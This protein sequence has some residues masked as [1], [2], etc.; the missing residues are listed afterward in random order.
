MSTRIWS[1]IQKTLRM[2]TQQVCGSVGW[3]H[4]A[5]LI[6]YKVLTLPCRRQQ[7]RL[8]YFVR[9]NSLRCV[10]CVRQWCETD[11]SSAG[12]TLH[13]ARCLSKRRR[14]EPS[15]SGPASIRLPWHVWS[16]AFWWWWWWCCH[17]HILHALLHGSVC[18][19]RDLS[20]HSLSVCS[21]PRPGPASPGP[22][23]RTANHRELIVAQLPETLPFNSLPGFTHS[24][25]TIKHKQLLIKLGRSEP[26]ECVWS[27]IWMWKLSRNLRLTRLES[28]MNRLLCKLRHLG[29]F[30]L[31]VRKS[32]DRQESERVGIWPKPDS[33]PNPHEPMNM[34]IIQYHSI[35]HQ[36]KI[37][38]Q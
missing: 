29:L 17:T 10:E 22:N 25:S 4:V 27:G 30:S 32:N 26:R 37:W 34:V 2:W 9:A 6:K 31:Y 1:R 24:L 12:L 33:N 35:W 8:L 3:T 14:C 20:E 36:W 28:R 16:Q 38:D 11:A 5:V 18:V 15:I 21:D 19:S 13:V 7:E 23:H